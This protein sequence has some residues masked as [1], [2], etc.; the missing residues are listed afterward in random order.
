M[1]GVRAIVVCCLEGGSRFLGEGALGTSVGHWHDGAPPLVTVRQKDGRALMARCREAPV[2][3]TV[4]LDV[5]I[6]RR[7][8][9]RNVC[10][11]F[12][13]ELSGAPVVMGAHHDGW[14][15]GAFDNVWVPE[16]RWGAELV[17][18]ET[19]GGWLPPSSTGL[20]GGW[21]SCWSSVV[22]Q[23]PKRC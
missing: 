18:G 22:D 11:V 20:F 8:N 12:A 7:A 1:R 3:V 2:R 13:P 21:L 14:F 15:F 10:G 19:I 16:T 5:E 9:G 23:M 4:T 6:S 17:V